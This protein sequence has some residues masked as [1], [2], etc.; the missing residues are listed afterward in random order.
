MSPLPIVPSFN[1]TLMYNEGAAF[2]FLSEAGGWQR[3]FFTAV[4]AIVSVVL[5]IWLLPKIWRALRG[6]FRAIGRFF[7]KA[8]TVDIA[9][10]Q[11]GHV[12]ILAQVHGHI[13]VDP[14]ITGHIGKT[15]DQFSSCR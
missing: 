2:S 3:W 10:E 4:K 14:A 15:L 12:Q 11:L 8:A 7:G 9:V 5:V 13:K 6:V 1:L